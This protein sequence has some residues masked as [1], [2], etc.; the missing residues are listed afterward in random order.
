MQTQIKVENEKYLGLNYREHEKDLEKLVTKMPIDIHDVDQLDEKEFAEIRNKAFGA[1]DSSILLQ[2]PYSTD[3]ITGTSIEDLLYNKEHNIYDEEISKKASVR[4]GRDLESLL[5][6]KAS[7]NFK[8]IIIKPKSMYTNLKGLTVNFD[9]ILFETD[10]TDSVIAQVQPIPVE[11]K[12]CTVWGKK[13]YDWSQAISEFNLDPQNF[14][15]ERPLPLVDKTLPLSEQ[16]KQRAKNLGIPAYYY[17]QL[18]QQMLFTKSNYGILAVMNDAEW[19]MNYFYV[20][21]DQEIINALEKI[22]YTNFIILSKRKGIQ[23]E[24]PDSDQEI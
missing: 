2:V 21:R 19:E 7:E 14:S 12:V 15:F 3:K 22:A 23:I 1:S 20:P 11:F 13:N 8:A 18:Q 17:T 6:Q 24:I 10:P 9:G 16:I 5:I 4:K